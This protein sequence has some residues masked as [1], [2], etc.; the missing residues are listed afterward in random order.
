MT[1]AATANRRAQ[2]AAEP[3]ASAEVTAGAS[4]RTP[5]RGSEPAPLNR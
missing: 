5:L 4:S 1:V 2:V 3:S